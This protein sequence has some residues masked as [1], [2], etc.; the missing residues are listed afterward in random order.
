ME[1]LISISTRVMIIVMMVMK[2]VVMILMILMILI[3]T[4][5]STMVRM[6]T[7]ISTRSDHTIRGVRFPLKQ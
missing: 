1:Q 6:R 7:R 5:A 3:V 2:M 4:M